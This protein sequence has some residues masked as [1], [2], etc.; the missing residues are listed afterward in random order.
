LGAGVRVPFD[1]YVVSFDYAYTVFVSIENVHRFTI[2]FSM[3]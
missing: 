2:S 3:K 1:E